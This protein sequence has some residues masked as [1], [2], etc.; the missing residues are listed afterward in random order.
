MEGSYNLLYIGDTS[1]RRGTDII[2]QAVGSLK[3]VIPNLKL[4][5]VG[6]SS[7]DTELKLLTAELGLEDH[8]CFEGWKDVQT[9]PS[10]IQYCDVALS[11]LKRNKHHD[12]TYANKIF[13]YMAL[14]KPVIASDCTTQAELISSEKCGVVY[15]ADNIENLIEVVKMFYGNPI[16]AKQMGA[17]GKSA[18]LQ[19]WNW[20]DTVSEM[21]LMYERITKT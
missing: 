4:W 6:K 3:N 16:I 12:T 13:Q 20:E 11:P 17:N 19:K 10:Y 15:Q 7:A 9:L 8:V 2:I 14:G 1:L 18:V 21:L 5:I